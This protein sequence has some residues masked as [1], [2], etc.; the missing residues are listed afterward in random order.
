MNADTNKHQCFRF[1]CPSSRWKTWTAPLFDCVSGQEFPESMHSNIYS[2]ECFPVVDN[3]TL[4]RP[5]CQ[6]ECL[7][8]CISSA[9]WSSIGI[10]NVFTAWSIIRNSLARRQHSM[11]YQV[12]F[13]T[14]TTEYT[15]RSLHHP[16]QFPVIDSCRRYAVLRCNSAN[17]GVGWF[18]LKL[19][20]TPSWYRTAL[21]T[22]FKAFAKESIF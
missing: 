16:K 13:I 8:V 18:L 14:C 4:D 10:S 9:A 19:K 3:N 5:M 2:T 7:Y 12:S 15:F 1:A 22:Q 17:H 11:C 6:Y 21:S 20:W